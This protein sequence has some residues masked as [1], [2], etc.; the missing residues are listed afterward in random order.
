MARMKRRYL[1]RR[2]YPADVKSRIQFWVIYSIDATYEE[3]YLQ[4]SPGK[5]SSRAWFQTNEKGVIDGSDQ[6]IWN[7][8]WDWTSDPDVKKGT[9]HQVFV[10]RNLNREQ[11]ERFMIDTEVEYDCMAAAPIFNHND[12]VG[13]SGAGVYPALKFKAR[14]YPHSLQARSLTQVG[15][16]RYAMVIVQPARMDYYPR[17]PPY[18][19]EWKWL[20]RATIRTYEDWDGPWHKRRLA[21]IQQHNRMHGAGPR[22]QRTKGVIN[23]PIQKR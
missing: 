17:K 5:L 1:P 11:F 23:V 12:L 6:T 18:K 3:E 16:D 7:E 22:S 2:T 9:Y 13:N 19:R 10:G 14:L 21:R 8:W 20:C 4:Y 15:P